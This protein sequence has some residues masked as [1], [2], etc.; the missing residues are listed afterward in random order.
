MATSQAPVDLIEHDPRLDASHVAIFGHSRYGKASLVAMAYDERLKAGFISSSG[1]GGAAPY[2][3]HWGEQVENVAEKLF[4]RR[5]ETAVK[6]CSR[7]KSW[8]YAHREAPAPVPP[9]ALTSTRMAEPDSSTI[10]TTRCGRW[11]PKAGYW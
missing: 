3:R 7:I 9:T 10:S 11:T 8:L 6:S 1:A 4:S 5:F 2:R